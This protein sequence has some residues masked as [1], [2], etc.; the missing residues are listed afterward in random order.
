MRSILA[1]VV[2]TALLMFCP[3]RSF[4]QQMF[5][6]FEGQPVTIE[7][8][9][10]G[11]HWLV[12]VIW[13]FRCPICQKELPTYA[14]L[15]RRQQS[16]SFIV[17]GLSIDGQEGFGGAWALLEELGN[18]FKSLIGEAD[19]VADFV[20]SHSRQPFRGTPT[21]MIFNPSGILVAFQG[22]PVPVDSIEG[23][24]AQRSN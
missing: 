15:A 2:C 1:V 4:G 20:L 23:F 6:N 3:E 5:E 8:Y 14:D 19:G 17:I 24:I 22:G 9:F 13:S 16:G 21:I 18:D 12:V 11:E 7:Q 10:D